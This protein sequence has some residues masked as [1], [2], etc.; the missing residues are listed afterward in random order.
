MIL[1]ALRAL[2]RNLSRRGFLTVLAKGG[3]AALAVEHFGEK[4]F[5]ADATSPYTI[6]SAIGN[7]TIPV[8]QDPGWVTFDPG[9]TEFALNVFVKQALLGG[10]ELAF[11]GVLGGL[12]GMNEIPLAIGYG[13]RFLEMSESFQITFFADIQASQFENDG[14]QDL[15]NL[16]F[17]L[18]VF[19][20]KCVFFSNYPDHLAQ[21]GAEFQVKEPASVKT[22]W[23]IIRFKGAV[24]PAEERMLRDRYM[25]VQVLPGVDRRNPYI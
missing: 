14:V 20:A 13:P 7:V 23:D 22:G 12:V 8:D 6:F 18:G 2:E 11:Q 25:N 10:D 4:L 15:L 16:G 3:G 24:G 19:T 17:S 21:Q 1:D 5:A 9:I